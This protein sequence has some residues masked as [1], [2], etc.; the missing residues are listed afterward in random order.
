M[1]FKQI[2]NQLKELNV[3]YLGFEEYQTGLFFRKYKF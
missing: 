3:P 1:N 2:E